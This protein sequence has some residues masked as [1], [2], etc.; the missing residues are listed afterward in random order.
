MDI[1]A[2]HN[3]EGMRGGIFLF[4]RN[5]RAGHDVLHKTGH[6]GSPAN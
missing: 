2:A 5:N 6:K 1:F 4:D 3:R